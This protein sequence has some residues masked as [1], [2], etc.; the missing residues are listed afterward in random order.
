M[1]E[2]N[3][4]FC[5]VSLFYTPVF[6]MCIRQDLAVALMQALNVC[7]WVCLKLTRNLICDDNKLDFVLV[8]SFSTLFSFFLISNLS[9]IRVIKPQM[10][11][12]FSLKLK[13]QLLGRTPPRCLSIDFSKLIP[14]ILETTLNKVHLMSVLVSM[15][16]GT[17]SW[18]DKQ[19]S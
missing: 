13:Q 7:V 18:S 16:P 12:N 8:F 10:N 1:Q 14:E 15:G 6:Q 17:W 5:L 11:V 19:T 4:C 9:W 2:S 3:L